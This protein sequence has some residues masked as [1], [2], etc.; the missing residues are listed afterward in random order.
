MRKDQQEQ[1][2]RYEVTYALTKPSGV[3]KLLRDRHR[4]GARRFRGDTAASDILIDLHTAIDKARLS[5]RQ[6]EAVAFV[7]GLDLTQ[8]E[9]AEVMDVTQQA[10]AK[11][12]DEA[13]RKIAAVYRKWDDKDPDGQYAEV[14]YIFDG[15]VDG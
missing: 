11:Y 4:I 8:S 14:T 2:R 15:E 3:K 13:V 5:R 9:A 6:A 10:V 1:T 7:Y 12:I